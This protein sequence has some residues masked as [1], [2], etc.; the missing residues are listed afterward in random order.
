M[1]YTRGSRRR[2]RPFLADL[3]FM[4][5]SL[6]QFRVSDLLV[7]VEEMKKISRKIPFLYLY[8]N[9]IPQTGEHCKSVIGFSVEKVTKNAVRLTTT[10]ATLS[11]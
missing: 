5:N 3:T 1:N 7:R 11:T 6:R 2:N 9:N 8:L 4:L 10:L